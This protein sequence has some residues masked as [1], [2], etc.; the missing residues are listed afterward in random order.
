MK[1]S[2]VLAAVLWAMLPVACQIDLDTTQET[3]HYVIVGSVASVRGDASRTEL[4][5]QNAVSS[6]GTVYDMVI[7][8]VADTPP[9]Y[10]QEPSG[11]LVRGDL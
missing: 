6:Y 7:V 9:I 3:E 10:R 1:G 8:V 5:V 11:S 2:Q 4:S